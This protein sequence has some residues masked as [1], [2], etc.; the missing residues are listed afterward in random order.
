M[1]VQRPEPGAEVVHGD[2]DSRLAIKIAAFPANGKNTPAGG[3]LAHGFD[4]VYDKVQKNL[5]ELDAVAQD[6]WQVPGEGCA[7]F[8]AMFVK[9]AAREHK[10][11]CNDRLELQRNFFR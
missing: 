7:G 6:G 11:V 4:A 8:N 9:L 1:F 10:N 3:D 5:L 2:E